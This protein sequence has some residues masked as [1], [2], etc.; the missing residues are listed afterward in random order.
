MARKDL[1]SERKAER[2]NIKFNA[3]VWSIFQR[4][5]C[6]TNDRKANRPRIR[7]NQKFKY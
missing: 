1:T 3:G 5:R 6:C 2:G 4:K 7:E